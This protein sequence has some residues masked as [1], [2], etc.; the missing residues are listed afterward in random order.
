MKPSFPRMKRNWRTTSGTHDTLGATVRGY[1][2]EW[3]F[4]M[5]ERLVGTLSVTGDIIEACAD[6]GILLR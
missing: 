5:S 6:M 1:F 4:L 3:L 2:D